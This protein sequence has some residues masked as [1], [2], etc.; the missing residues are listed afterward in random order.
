[1]SANHLVVWNVRSLNSRTRRNV[2]RDIVEQQQASIVCLQESKVANPSVSMNTELTGCDYD[3]V[4]LPAVGVA[5][6]A[7]TFWRRDLWASDSGNAR[8]FSI[9]THLT[10]LNGPGAPWWVTNVYGLTADVDKD[11]FLRE[12]RE[13]SVV[14]HGPWLICGDFN[15]IHAAADKNN[16]RL[17]HGL[18]RRFCRVIDDLQLEELHLSGRRF[19]WSNGRDT[20]TLERLD[21]AFASVDWMEQY[22]NNTLRGLSSDSS[23]HAPLL[24][25]LNSE[26]WATPRFRFDHCWPKFEGFLDVV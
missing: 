10:P 5:G 4:Y 19:T 21:R 1:M 13:L 18:M 23:D 11:D 9:T 15:M 14:C 16:D 20:P 24:L 22:P 17:N 12:L 8:R 3:Y 26:P 7:I 25:T 6:G 2:V